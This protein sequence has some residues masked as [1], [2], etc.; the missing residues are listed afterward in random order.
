[1]TAPRPPAG[2]PLPTTL[3]TRV[4][5]LRPVTAEGDE[6][7]LFIGRWAATGDEV[8]VT[9][10]AA[11][12]APPTHAWRQWPK[13]NSALV[14]QLF[15]ARRLH[16]YDYE[17]VRHYPGGT[18]R[19]LLCDGIPVPSVL[20]LKWVEQLVRAINH[21]HTSFGL[22]H[23]AITPDAIAVDVDAEGLRQVRLGGLGWARTIRGF[24]QPV[25][26]SSMDLWAGRMEP[27]ED[28]IELVPTGDF[29]YVAPEPGPGEWAANDY[30]SLG[31]VLLELLLG[32]Y[33]FPVAAD[34]ADK[35]RAD[36]LH[37]MSSRDINAAEYLGRVEM[38]PRLATLI[39]GLLTQDAAVR[40]GAAQVFACLN[41]GSPRLLRP[42]NPTAVLSRTTRQQT[43]ANSGPDYVFLSYSRDDRE[44]AL[45]LKRHL[46]G[47]GIRAWMDDD[48]RTG[49]QWRQVIDDRVRRSAAV[50]VVMS[51]NALVSPWVER[52]LNQA[53]ACQRPILPLLLEGDRF[54]RL[55]NV[56]YEDVVGARMPSDDFVECLR[57]YLRG[58][59]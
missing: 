6:R 5:D 45:R 11:L 17:V 13:T 59:R 50:I 58:G 40:W 27:G 49:E 3:R 15:F 24:A 9:R 25:P 39:D 14:C 37:L 32:R 16:G 2:P 53:E 38:E 35:G 10:R 44:Y 48:V 33:P 18:L 1:M 55:S 57:G 30:W 22:V 7:A 42:V 23:S 56:Q 29:R 19:D 34:A 46:G 28:D 52:E 26:V 21:L 41:G 47:C 43:T 31:V 36:L 12:G 4:V 54:S 8:I 51:P 20:V